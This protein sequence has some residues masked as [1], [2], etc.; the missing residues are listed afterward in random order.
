MTAER[1]RDMIRFLVMAQSFAIAMTALGCASTV[2]TGESRINEMIDESWRDTRGFTAKFR[3]AMPPIPDDEYGSVFMVI[4]GT[5]SFQG[6]PSSFKYRIEGEDKVS[7]DVGHFSRTRMMYG[8]D[9]KYGYIVRS[10]LQSEPP[11]PPSM[12]RV[13]RAPL[14]VRIPG[15]SEFPVH[16]ALSLR[17]EDD[18][19]GMIIEEVAFPG[20]GRIYLLTFPTSVGMRSG[21][22]RLY[23]SKQNGVPLKQ[24]VFIKDEEEPSFDMFQ[25]IEYTD[26]V[27]NPVVSESEFVFEVPSGHRLTDYQDGELVDVEEY[28]E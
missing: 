12:D 9:G 20:Y 24:E 1:K 25:I 8:S 21:Q 5:V 18:L 3:L 10:H 14:S 22:T 7:V 16:P 17:V 19:S 13:L 15:V 26:I 11:F 27:I 6:T 23:F 4:K 28:S 2:V